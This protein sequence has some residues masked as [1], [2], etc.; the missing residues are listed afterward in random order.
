MWSKIRQLKG[1]RQTFTF[2]NL[3][4]QNHTFTTH[5]EIS[6]ILAS[7]YTKISDNSNYNP[8]FIPT[9]LAK[10]SYPIDFSLNPLDSSPQDYNQPIS[11]EEV[12]FAIDKAP[13][14]SA[15]GHDQ[16]LSIFLQKIHPNAITHLTKLINKIFLQGIYSDEWKTAIITPILKPEKDPTSPLSYRPI[17]FLCALSKTIERILNKRLSWFLESNNL[18][19]QHQYGGLK[20]RSAPMALLKLDG[21]IHHANSNGQKLLSVF[22][23]LESA[24][25]RV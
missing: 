20:G 11:E 23:D 3:T 12:Y 15:P 24:F 10:E 21:M 5:E 13:K 7:T 6:K 22:I 17:S 8:S 9:K 1:H 25:P 14:N 2:Q 16:I 18:I 4:Y 19:S